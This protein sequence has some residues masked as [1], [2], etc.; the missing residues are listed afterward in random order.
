MCSATKT[1]ILVWTLRGEK[2]LSLGEDDP[3]S[4]LI[5]P[6][7]FFP[8]AQS[9]FLL[10]SSQIHHDFKCFSYGPILRKVDDK[11]GCALGQWFANF[12]CAGNT[13]GHAKISLLVLCCNLHSYF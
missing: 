9:S 11:A 4:H 2:T 6:L 10:K 7:T 1:Q 12:M 8:N 3:V 5:P 13:K